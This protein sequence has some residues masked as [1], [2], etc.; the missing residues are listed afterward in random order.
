[1][2]MAFDEKVY[3]EV[4]KSKKEWSLNGNSMYRAQLIYERNLRCPEDQRGLDY[5]L[6][7]KFDY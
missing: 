3:F 6:E 4:A 5:V 1:M 7:G 2:D